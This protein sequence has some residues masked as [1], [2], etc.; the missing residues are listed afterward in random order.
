MLKLFCFLLAHLNSFFNSYFFFKF[1]NKCQKMCLNFFA[2]VW[3]LSFYPKNVLVLFLNILSNTLIPNGINV[4]GRSVIL[5][6]ILSSLLQE[7][8]KSRN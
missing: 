5:I 3:F 2:C 8:K 1:I 7:I 4:S 6:S